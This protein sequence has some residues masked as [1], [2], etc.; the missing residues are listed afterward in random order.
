MELSYIREIYLK[1]L[2]KTISQKSDFKVA[3]KGKSAWTFS[4]ACN[5]PKTTSILVPL[6]FYRKK[7]TWK[8]CGLFSHHNYLKKS[9]WKHCGFF[10]ERN[11]TKKRR[12]NIVDFS[13]FEITSKKVRGKNVDI[14]TLKIT[15]KKVRGKNVDCY[16]IKIASK[17]YV[18]M[19]W[20]FVKLWSPMYGRNIDVG[21]TSIL[22]GVPA[23]Y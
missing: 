13:T 6:K 20:K 10:D 19:M 8:Q 22:R 15:S 17:R 9:K 4:L 16:A 18:E 23:G 1:S 5:F 3:N 14:S 7:S 12:G 2:R 11:Y 21:S